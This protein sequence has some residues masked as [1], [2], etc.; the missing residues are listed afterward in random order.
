[1]NLPIRTSV[2]IGSLAAAGVP[3]LAG[4]MPEAAN[5]AAAATPG[6]LPAWM[7]SIIG[8]SARWALYALGSSVLAAVTAAMHARAAS[9][10]LAAARTEDPSDDAKAASSAAAWDAAADKLEQAGKNLPGG[11][12]A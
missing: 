6:G 9:L 11:P 3:L 5:A 12:R 10:R 7:L 1:M 8:P 2:V 4:A